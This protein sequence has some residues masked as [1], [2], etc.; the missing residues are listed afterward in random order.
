MRKVLTP[1]EKRAREDKLKAISNNIANWSFDVVPTIKFDEA[2]AMLIKEAVERLI[3]NE[4]LPHLS[5]K[6]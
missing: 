6:K 1:E 2:E 4:M 3:I 5:G